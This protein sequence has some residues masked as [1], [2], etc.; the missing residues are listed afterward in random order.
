MKTERWEK[1]NEEGKV[2]V[3]LGRYLDEEETIDKRYLKEVMDKRRRWTD[4]G[5][6]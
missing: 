2:K 6:V 4:L 3:L 1:L 5:K